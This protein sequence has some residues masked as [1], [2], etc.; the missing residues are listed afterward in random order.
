MT[1]DVTAALWRRV[2]WSPLFWAAV[3]AGI[4]VVTGRAGMA[5]MPYLFALV[6]GVL[7]GTSFVM[8]TL[9][10]SPPWLGVVVHVAGALAGA[11]LLWAAIKG[12]LPST[13]PLPG[14]WQRLVYWVQLG[15]GPM[16][17]WI[18]MGLLGRVSSRFDRDARTRAAQKTRVDW[19]RDGTAWRLRFAAVPLRMRT[20]TALI[21][22]VTLVACALA[23]IGMIVFYDVVLRIGAYG[24][25]FAFALGIGL[26][27]YLTLK[28]LLRRRTATFDLRIEATR[29]VLT[30]QGH[31]PMAV[32]LQALTL[33]R[34]QTTSDHARLELAAVDV[35]AMSLLAGVARVP[36]SMSAELPALP[37]MVVRWLKSAGLREVPARHPSRPRTFRRPVAGQGVDRHAPG[38]AGP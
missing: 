5:F 37:T 3:C 18:W 1:G 15:A 10:M 2:R 19:T 13:H 31:P 21:V 11:V 33:L 6:A 23:A 34:W 8:A 14:S 20:L 38:A 27:G 12:H 28:A 36:A 22:A 35:E 4:T 26:P 16:I 32:D 17:G 29:L 9:R 7:C 25:I 30:R 24:A